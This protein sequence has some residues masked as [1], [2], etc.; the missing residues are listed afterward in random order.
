[1]QYSPNATIMTV[2]TEGSDVVIFGHVFTHPPPS[3][4]LSLFPLYGYPCLALSSAQWERERQRGCPRSNSKEAS[5]PL[6]VVLWSDQPV[7]SVC[8]RPSA[9][10][11]SVVLVEQGQPCD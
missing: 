9:S 6:V 5:R 10:C 4:S 7:S 8:P 11:L 3:S 1:M 2:R